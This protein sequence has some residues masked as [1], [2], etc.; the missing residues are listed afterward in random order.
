MRAN[1]REVSLE[2][3]LAATARVEAA[4]AAIEALDLDAFLHHVYR[5][6]LV[7]SDPEDRAARAALA[8][9]TLPLNVLQRITGGI[10]AGDREVSVKGWTRA[11]A[12]LLSVSGAAGLQLSTAD[13][14]GSASRLA[15]DPELLGRAETTITDLLTTVLGL[16][17]AIALGGAGDDTPVRHLLARLVAHVAQ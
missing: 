1:S 12:I 15:S 8:A 13:V 17:A 3:G 6:A 5:D 9:G 2:D 4:C 10:L 7:H 11:A 16:Q 14:R